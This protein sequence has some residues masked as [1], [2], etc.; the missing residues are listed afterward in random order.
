MKKLIVLSSLTLISIGAYAQGTVVFS[1]YEPGNDVFHIYSPIFPGDTTE[2]IGN[3]TTAYS[4]PS[5]YGGDF[6]VGGT[7][8]T[9]G[10]N[11]V[12][13][14][15]GNFAGATMLGGTSGG[16]TGTL[17]YTQGSQFTVQLLAAAGL[18]QSLGSLSPV[19]GATSSFYTTPAVA[20]GLFTGN[21]TIAIP[22]ANNYQ[23][24]VAVAA[25]WNDNG[26]ITSLA[27]AEI[28]PGEVWG[29]GNTVNLTQL[30]EPGSITGGTPGT[31]EN[32]YGLESF[33]L[34]TTPS[35]TPEPSMIALG[36]IGV[37]GFLARRRK[38]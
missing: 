18:N 17:N 32:L 30:G 16:A 25:W 28:T 2:V 22:G 34:Q 33:S 14:A 15:T 11:S 38:K 12:T 8:T 36:L 6:P 37:G 4:S 1:D 3:S 19:S 9:L 10:G 29:I 24:T 21:P 20:A 26:T 23:A 27:Q 13:I 5:D 7:V 31:A 35:T